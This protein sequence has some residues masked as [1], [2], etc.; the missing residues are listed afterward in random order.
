MQNQKTSL[1]D[2]RVTIM[3]SPL[4]NQAIR[5]LQADTIKKTQRSW[6]FSA[7]LSEVLRE[8]LRNI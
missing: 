2:L 3:L 6:S 1:R 4:L 7:Q 5:K 8:G